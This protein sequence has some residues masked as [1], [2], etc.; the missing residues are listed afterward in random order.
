MSAQKSSSSKSIS[1]IGSG[2]KRQGR[3]ADEE[4]DCDRDSVGV[5]SFSRVVCIFED[6]RVLSIVGSMDIVLDL[7]SHTL[8]DDFDSAGGFVD[9]G[10]FCFIYASNFTS[11]SVSLLEFGLDVAVLCGDFFCRF[12]V[13]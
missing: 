3:K 6:D 7:D 8:S 12:D 11:R 13:L 1:G 5:P 2:S 4:E 9:F 10:Y